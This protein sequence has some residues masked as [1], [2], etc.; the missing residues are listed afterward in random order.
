MSR[1]L[2]GIILIRYCSFKR[3]IRKW[4]SLMPR[5]VDIGLQDRRRL[6]EETKMSGCGYISTL[7]LIERAFSWLPV[8]QTA[9]QFLQRTTDWEVRSERQSNSK[10]EK[11]SSRNSTSQLRTW[12]VV[13][14]NYPCRIHDS[15]PS[16]QSSP[17]LIP[18]SLHMNEGHHCKY[19]QHL[20]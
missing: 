2:K 18:I 4:T 9:A 10:Q 20:G 14:N 12:L 8:Y 17:S 1:S 15:S 16:S 5:W 19:E 7:T 6:M 11:Q 13:S 3:N